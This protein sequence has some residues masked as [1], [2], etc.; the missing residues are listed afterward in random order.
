MENNFERLA[1]RLKEKSFKAYKLPPD[2]SDKF[3][4][5][6]PI[7]FPFAKALIKSLVPDATEEFISEQLTFFYLGRIPDI[8]LNENEFF[9]RDNSFADTCKG[10]VIRY[11]PDKLPAVGYAVVEFADELFV[12]YISPKSDNMVKLIFNDEYETL[13]LPEELITVK[14]TPV[15]YRLPNETEYRIINHLI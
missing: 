12:A 4:N 13:L 3:L 15:I 6:T 2:I 1:T 14:G 7:A 5:L 8:V 10:T 9:A 11:D